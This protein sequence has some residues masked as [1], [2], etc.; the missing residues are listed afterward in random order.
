MRPIFKAPKQRVGPGVASDDTMNG[1]ER[2]TRSARQALAPLPDAKRKAGAHPSTDEG[3]RPG[4][5]EVGNAVLIA[6]N[7][8]A[9]L[10]VLVLIFSYYGLAESLVNLLLIVAPA[11]LIGWRF[12]GGNRNGDSGHRGKRRNQDHPPEDRGR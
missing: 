7:V 1:M 8:I 5:P 6:I 9:G 2:P 3:T 10:A 4:I 12:L 11:L